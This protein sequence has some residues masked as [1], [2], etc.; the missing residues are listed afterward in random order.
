I[1]NCIIKKTLVDQ[2]SSTDILFWNTFKQI[3][4]PESEILPHDDPLFG[5]LGE[6]VGTKGSIWLYTKFGHE[7]ILQKSLKLGYMI[8]H[9]HTSYN[10]LLGCPSLNALGVIMSIPHLVM[11][12]LSNTGTITTMHANQRTTKECYMVNLRL[13]PHA[14]VE[15]PR[16]A[17][18]TKAKKKAKEVKPIEDMSTLQL[19]PNEE[20][21]TQ[22]GNQLSS[23]NQSRIQRTI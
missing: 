11:K 22:L 2:W 4:I 7:G 9:A 8:M 15:A 10:I 13:C 6:K 21:V 20:P 1:V 3:E 18:Y 5:F 12:F 19:S 17:H 14:R 16:V 23:D